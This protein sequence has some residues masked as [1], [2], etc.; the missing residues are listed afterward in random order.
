MADPLSVD[1][2]RIDL[3]SRFIGNSTVV[4]STLSATIS[5]VAAVTWS[6]ATNP[7]V[8]SGILV[9]GMASFTTG[10]AATGAKLEIRRGT[11]AG[12]VVSGATTGFTLVTAAAIYALSVNGVDTVAT[13][14]GQTWVLC[15]TVSSSTATNTVASA[16]INAIIV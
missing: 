15:L 13:T 16:N 8:V 4:G 6:P 9:E 10:T 1:A 3:S 5:T 7:A 14:P 2:G 12:A 11:S